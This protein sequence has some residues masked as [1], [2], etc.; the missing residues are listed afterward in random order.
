MFKLPRNKTNSGQALI[1]V[2]LGM[3]VVLTLVISIVSTSVTDIDV[4]TRDEEAVRAL[5]AAEAGI[6]QGFLVATTTSD[7]FPDN[8]SAFTATVTGV[9]ESSNNYNLPENLETGETG[10]LWYVS[11]DENGL[12]CDA[13]HPCVAGAGQ[14]LRV[15]FSPTGTGVSEA[16]AVEISFFYDESASGVA[17]GNFSQV[18][19]A[20]VAYDPNASRILNNSFTQAN[21]G[22]CVDVDGQSYEFSTPAI[23]L[24]SLGIGCPPGCLLFARVKP[25]YNTTAMPIGFISSAI[26]PSQ[27]VKVVSTGTSGDSTRTLEAFRSYKEPPAVFDAAIFSNS[28]LT[29]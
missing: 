7:E 23:D 12:A 6:E 9:A 8:N 5:N 4:S 24:D 18:K 25:L 10:T 17:T 29:K 1:L 22:N 21:G 15:C 27:G 20:R 13:E 26:L 2:L 28:G 11:H 3:A 16:P 14:T 19:V